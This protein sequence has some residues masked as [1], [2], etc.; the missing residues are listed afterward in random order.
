MFKNFSLL[1]RFSLFKRKEREK[2]MSIVTF[3]EQSFLN[4][5]F[6]F[7]LIRN[8]LDWI[9]VGYH[10][11]ATPSSTSSS[12]SSTNGGNS[13]RLKHDYENVSTRG[14]TSNE[15]NSNT[16]QQQSSSWS[17]LVKSESSHGLRGKD[18]QKWNEVFQWYFRSLF[19]LYQSIIF[20]S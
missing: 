5:T 8:Y 7:V 13:S 16:G 1:M 4:Q 17:S 19:N 15:S 6:F 10:T 18:Q 9:V 20:S 2:E 12:A 14:N 3:I 11:T